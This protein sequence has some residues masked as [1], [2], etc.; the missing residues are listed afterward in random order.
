MPQLVRVS[1]CAG[2]QKIA[3]ARETNSKNMA[4]I[5]DKVTR[6]RMM[7]GIRGKDTEPE[8]AVRRFLHGRGLRFRL[9]RR[10]LP[11]CPDIVFPKYGTVVFVHGCFW[12]RHRGCQFTTTPATRREF[13]LSKFQGNVRRDRSQ[14][15]ELRRMGWRVSVVWE[16]EIGQERKLRALE[17]EIKGGSKKNC[18]GKAS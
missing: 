8:L 4:D 17:R 18:G 14:A 3:D 2:S 13:W 10:D 1:A 7:A 16:C 9:H 12:H 15:R 5:V 11:G 6:S